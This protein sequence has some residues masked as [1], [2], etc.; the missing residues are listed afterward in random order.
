[1][2]TIKK[3]LL[4][5]ACVLAFRASCF[6]SDNGTSGGMFLRIDPSAQ[7]ASMSDAMTSIGEN[8]N[9]IDFNP[10]GISHLAGY[11]TFKFSFSHIE[12]LEDVKYE[13]MKFATYVKQ[14][15]GFVG[16]NLKYLYTSDVRRDVWGESN[17]NFTD[18]NSA[19]GLSYARRAGGTDFGFQLKYISEKLADESAAG[20]VAADA[21]LMYS[22]YLLPFDVGV[23]LRNIGTSIGYGSYKD[24]LPFEARL[25]ISRDFETFLLSADAVRER[26]GQVYGNIGAS[27]GIMN[28]FK[29]RAGYTTLNRYSAGFGI[30][31][32]SF[33]L[34]Y[35]FSPFSKLSGDVHRFSFEVK[36]GI[37][38]AARNTSA[39][40]PRRESKKQIKTAPKL[41]LGIKKRPRVKAA[42]QATQPEQGTEEIQPGQG[43]QTEQVAPAEQSIP[44]RRV[45]AQRYEQPVQAEQKPAAVN[46]IKV[47]EEIQVKEETPSG[48]VIK[49]P[50]EPKKEDSQEINVIEEK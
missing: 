41:M 6:S 36:F 27:A 28:D 9:S 12:Y 31:T 14:V 30:Q 4:A 25:G 49:N 50:E 39:E 10:A 13:D 33:S 40:T 43:T 17:G 11:N 29:L 19:F 26:E 48:N 2:R 38:G 1:M 15:K 42:E 32:D 7:A 44:E 18:S 21:G 45:P 3:L 20:A 8:L 23:S 24:P 37:K 16:L 35:A 46:E 34:D 5:F 47:Q 22:A